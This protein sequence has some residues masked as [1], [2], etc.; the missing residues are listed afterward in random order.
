MN[1][2]LFKQVR[3]GSFKRFGKLSKRVESD[4]GGI[5]RFNLLK[6]FIFNAS[7]FGKVFLSDLVFCTKRL[8]FFSELAVIICIH[9]TIL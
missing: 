4:I 9:F 2:G 6:V 8:Y 5:V 1:K 3:G 7:S